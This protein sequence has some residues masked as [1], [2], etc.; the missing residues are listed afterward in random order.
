MCNVIP[1]VELSLYRR[2]V[3]TI[4]VIEVTEVSNLKERIRKIRVVFTPLHS[5]HLSI[6]MY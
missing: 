5:A 1:A 6:L 4:N 2:S 3:S